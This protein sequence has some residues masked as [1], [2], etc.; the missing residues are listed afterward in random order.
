VLSIYISFS[1]ELD[2]TDE[3]PL[4]LPRRDPK[5]KN[6]SRAKFPPS[7]SPR[8]APSLRFKKSTNVIY[9]APAIYISSNHRIFIKNKVITI[10]VSP[11]FLFFAALFFYNNWL[12]A[13][14]GVS[15]GGGKPRAA[16]F[17]LIELSVRADASLK[18]VTRI[19]FVTT[20]QATLSKVHPLTAFRM[21]ARRLSR[22]RATSRRS[23]R[24]R[25]TATH[26]R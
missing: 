15:F 9:T 1:I 25:R 17:F 7:Y 13:W 10:R 2:F 21:L 12:F 24:A 22:T 6:T 18:T 8:S 23:A 26:R 19:L 11:N 3:G 20:N 16:P 14:W 5:K 4:M